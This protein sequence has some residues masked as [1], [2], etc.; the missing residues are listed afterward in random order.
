MAGLFWR[1]KLFNN[2][3]GVPLGRLSAA[4]SLHKVIAGHGSPHLFKFLEEPFFEEYLQ[5]ILILKYDE[6]ADSQWTLCSI[7]ARLCECHT[8]IHDIKQ[9][10]T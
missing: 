3:K 6:L 8:D 9:V 7:P 2:G 1:C 5:E 10:L 4:Q